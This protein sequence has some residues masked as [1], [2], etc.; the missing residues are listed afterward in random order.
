MQTEQQFSYQ[1]CTYCIMDNKSDSYITFNSQGQCNYC[2]HTLS[3]QN[4]IYFPN[5]EGKKKLNSLISKL[6]TE[7]KIKKYDCVMGISGGLDSSYLAYLGSV[8]WGLRILA[9]HIDDGFD[10]KISQRN[11]DKISKFPNIDL[12]II[13][14]DTHQFNE[15][16]KAYM[17][18]GV[19]NL[20]I[21]QDNVLFANLYLFMKQNNI[22]TFLSGGNFAL[23]SILQQGNTYHAYDI[24]NL[25]SINKRFGTT[26]LDKLTLISALKYDINAY[27]MGVKSLRPLNFLDYNRDRA[28]QELQDY[29]GFEYYGS[30]HLENT[31]T[32]FI[33]QYWFY[34]KFNV[35]KRTSHLS[36]MIVSRQMPREDA[37]K[38]YNQPLYDNN[39]MQ[40]TIKEVLNQLNMSYEEFNQIMQEPAKQHTDYPTSLYLKVKPYVSTI[41]KKLLIKN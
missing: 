30:K 15:L 34:H 38:L 11:I 37:L 41:I 5:E 17:R 31:L 13:K 39:D 27:I 22:N 19:P 4:K 25:K 12:H 10:T 14:P 33:Q 2:S 8:I 26:K 40:L 7:N 36:S 24:H 23:E 1:Q 35:D 3:I 28:M 20:A 9:V 16:T 6:K 21:P 18:A 29:C 32:K